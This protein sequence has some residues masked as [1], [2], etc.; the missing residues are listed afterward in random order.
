M[1]IAR[2]MAVPPVRS[3]RQALE[4]IGPGGDE[5]LRG[6]VLNNSSGTVRHW[7]RGAN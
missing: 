7:A 6:K 5:R 2:T 4:L 1:A 3:P